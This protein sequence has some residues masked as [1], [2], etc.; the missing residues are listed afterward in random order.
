ML[1][2]IQLVYVVDDTVYYLLWQQRYQEYA[3][4]SRRRVPLDD[5]YERY[6]SVQSERICSNMLPVQIR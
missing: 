2:A 3:V 1:T 5:P 4:P 6:V